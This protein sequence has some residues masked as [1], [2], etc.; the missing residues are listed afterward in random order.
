MTELD[1]KDILDGNRGSNPQIEMLK[2]VI[3]QQ[4]DRA[5]DAVKVSA[6]PGIQVRNAGKRPFV[7][8]DP[9]SRTRYQSNS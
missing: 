3:E 9:S 4:I 6:T 2:R 5:F 8:H 7:S 1:I